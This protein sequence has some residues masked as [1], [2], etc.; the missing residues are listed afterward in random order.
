MS[1]LRQRSDTIPPE[2][3]V[4]GKKTGMIYQREIQIQT[5]QHGQMRNLT[6]EIAQV[7]GESR[8]RS[9]VV[10]I[11]NAKTPRRKELLDWVALATGAFQFWWVSH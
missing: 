4:P 7:V 5:S 6:D 8:V 2:W 11:F 9:G 10:N 3:P 1:A